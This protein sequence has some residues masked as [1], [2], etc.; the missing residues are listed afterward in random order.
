MSQQIINIGTTPGDGTGD[1][2]RVA[3][4][5]CN[6]NFTELY[7]GVGSTT[8]GIWNFNQTSTD[9]T[10]SPTSGR[11]RTNTGDYATA[12]QIAIHQTTINGI[13]RSNILRTQKAGDVI[14]C[15]D[16]ANA[17]SWCRFIVASTPIDNSTWFQ[18]NVTSDSGGGTAPGNNQEIIFIFSASGGA[19]GGGG[20]NVSNVGTPTNG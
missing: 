3:F 7:A 6:Q 12:T 18:F 15:Q 2:A 8:Q 14:K 17:N 20:G 4:D 11:F 10:T 5:K 1:Q 19:G 16:P 13:D 9:T